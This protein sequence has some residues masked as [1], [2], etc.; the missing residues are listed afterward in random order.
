MEES[1][2]RGRIPA[3]L[4]DYRIRVKIGIPCAGESKDRVRAI[5]GHKRFPEKY[6]FGS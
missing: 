4:G 5:V 3:G 2:T 6:L 1:L